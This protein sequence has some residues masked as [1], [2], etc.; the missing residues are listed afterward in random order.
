MLEYKHNYDKTVET[1][2]RDL[3]P[4]EQMNQMKNEKIRWHTEK[5]F[6]QNRISSK[7]FGRKNKYCTA[8]NLG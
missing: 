7:G 2:L 4:D 1:S 8:Y 3:S 5:N 6:F